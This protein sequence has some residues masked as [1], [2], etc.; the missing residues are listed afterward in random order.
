VTLSL[1]TLN[2]ITAAWLKNA[3]CQKTSSSEL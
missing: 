3:S 1:K 2:R